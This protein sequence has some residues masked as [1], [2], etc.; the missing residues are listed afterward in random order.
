ML[1]SITDVTMENNLSRVVAAVSQQLVTATTR[2]L[3]VSV[4]A[5]RGEVGRACA[6]TEEWC[7]RRPRPGSFWEGCE[8]LSSLTVRATR[9]RWGEGSRHRETRKREEK[10]TVSDVV[11][12]DVY[13]ISVAVC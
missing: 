13:A 5:G 10:L 9:A 3:T 4:P 11:R 1:P 7:S 6:G 12:S 8:R 2:A